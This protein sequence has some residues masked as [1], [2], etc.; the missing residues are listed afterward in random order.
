MY[1][2]DIV[3]GRVLGAGLLADIA[4]P[5]DGGPFPVILDV[6][7]GRWIRSSKSNR[8][9]A[10]DVQQWSGLGFFAMDIDYRLV[11]CTPAPACYQDMQCAIRWVHAHAE[12]YNLDVDRIFLIGMSCGGHMVSLAATLGDGKF[13]RTGGWEDQSNDF[14]GVISSA[15]A[16]DLIKLDWGAGWMPIGESWDSARKY[17]SPLTHVSA[18]TKPLLI[19]HSDTDRSVPIQQALDMADALGKAGAPFEFRHYKDRGHMSITDEVVEAST[20]FIEKVCKN[21]PLSATRVDIE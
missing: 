5:D 1:H 20:A 9:T 16:Y 11:T 18:E 8:D 17:G 10:I 14:R 21:E 19:V 6:H 7:G 4:S 12:Q 3:Y 15:G 13:A 2:Q